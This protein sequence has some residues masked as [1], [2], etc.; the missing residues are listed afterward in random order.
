MINPDHK[1]FW[2]KFIQAHPEY[3]NHPQPQ[4]FYFCDNQDDADECADLVV[5]GIKQATATSLWWFEKHDEPLPKAGDLAIVTNWEGVPMAIIETTHVVPRPYHQIDEEFA[6]SE[7]EGD[8]SLQYW[9]RVH[10]AYYN[11]EMNP[12]GEEF[13]EDMII[14]CEYFRTVYTP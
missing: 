13:H 4:S 1:P 8:G 2:E 7:G 3:Q 10:K 12:H 5:R 14:M 6:A 9:Q 11:R